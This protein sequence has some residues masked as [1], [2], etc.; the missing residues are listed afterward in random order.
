MVQQPAMRWGAAL[1]VPLV[2][3]AGL[4]LTWVCW[5]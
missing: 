1:C 2:Q 3:G 4:D 5:K